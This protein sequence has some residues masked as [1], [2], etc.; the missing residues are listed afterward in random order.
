[1]VLGFRPEETEIHRSAQEGALPVKVETVHFQGDRLICQLR[2]GAEAIQVSTGAREQI[3]PN[4]AVW[5][6]VPPTDIHLFD[7]ESGAR[8]GIPGVDATASG[9][10]RL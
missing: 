8:V 1:M 9:A 5:V 7:R 2:L 10:R 6:T 3:V 4:A